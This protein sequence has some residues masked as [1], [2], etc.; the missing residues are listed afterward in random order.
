MLSKRLEHRPR[1]GAE[2][3]EALDRIHVAAPS[4]GSEFPD[5]ITA[6]RIPA[7]DTLVTGGP[8]TVERLRESAKLPG[9]SKAP[10]SMTRVMK[11]RR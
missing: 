9:A 6:V 4:D 1:D 11:K 2:V 10:A 5:S 8:G 3:A 7:D